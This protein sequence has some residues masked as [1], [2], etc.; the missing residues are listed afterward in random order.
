MS[1]IFSNK[2]RAKSAQPKNYTNIELH[3][4]L[5]DAKGY[6]EYFFF[7]KSQV[8]M[9]F[10]QSK[11][12]NHVLQSAERFYKQENSLRPSSSQPSFKRGGRISTHCKTG[13]LST[14]YTN[15]G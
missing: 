5:D 15:A 10:T 8:K 2:S 9:H 11:F 4:H 1:D 12:E 6:K 14:G 7:Y 3:S 13:G